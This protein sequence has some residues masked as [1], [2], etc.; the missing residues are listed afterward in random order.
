MDVKVETS[1]STTSRKSTIFE[2]YSDC[3]ASSCCCCGVCDCGCDCF[4][5]RNSMEALR[6]P[7]GLAVFCLE[8]GPF[9]DSSGTEGKWRRVVLASDGWA[10][11]VGRCGSELE[12]LRPS[13]ALKLPARAFPCDCSYCCCLTFETGGAPLLD[14]WAFSLRRPMDD[15]WRLT[16]G[17]A[18]FVMAGLVSAGG[19]SRVGVA[20]SGA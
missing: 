20:G 6:P 18:L 10:S 15:C 9:S 16:A 1:G 14:G 3:A 12:R 4:L 17:L 8:L 7:P 19:R 5:E 2:S 11:Q 13:A